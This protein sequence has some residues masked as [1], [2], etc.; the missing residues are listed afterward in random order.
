MLKLLTVVTCA[1]LIA[2]CSPNPQQ[3]K[4]IEGTFTGY[5][6]GFENGNRP[7]LLGVLDGGT[8]LDLRPLCGYQMNCDLDI[9][10]GKKIEVEFSEINDGIYVTERINVID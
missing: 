7:Y 9:S 6:K 4:S 10:T 8:W 5:D 1:I 2:A 3:L